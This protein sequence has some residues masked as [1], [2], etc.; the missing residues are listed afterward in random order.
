MSALQFGI[1]KPLVIARKVGPQGHGH[2]RIVIQAEPIKE[3]KG[4]KRPD[5]PHPLVIVRPKAQL[6]LVAEYVF[7]HVRDQGIFTHQVQ[8]PVHQPIIKF[9]L[10]LDVLGFKGQGML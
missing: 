3:I 4:F 2:I 10:D 9:I 7:I 6:C 5:H 1:Q 8:A